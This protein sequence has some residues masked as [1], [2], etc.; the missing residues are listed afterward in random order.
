MRTITRLSVLTLVVILFTIALFGSLAATGE[1]ETR[2]LEK[3]GFSTLHYKSRQNLMPPAYGLAPNTTHRAANAAPVPFLHPYS[4]I[5]VGSWPQVLAAADFTGDNLADLAL[6]SASYFDP[7]NDQRLHLYSG[8]PLTRTQRLPAGADPAAIVAADLDGDGASD[9][10]LALAGDDALALYTQPLTNPTTL[11]LPGA[12]DALASG[13]LNGDLRPDLAAVAPLSA[14]LYLWEGQ[15]AASGDPTLLFALPFPTGGYDALAIGDLDDDGDDDIVALRGAGYLA[16]SVVVYLQQSGSFPLSYTLTPKTGG[17]LPHSLAVGDVNGDG[18]DD[19]V[20]TAGGNAP[21]AY[22]NVFLQQAGTLAMASRTVYSAHHLPSAVAIADLNHDG[23]QDVIAL[24]DAWQ[25]LSV[26]TQTISGTLA[27]YTVAPIPYS[28]R[29]RPDALS[30]ADL[31][32]DGGLDAALVDR[33][34]G[35][36]V[37]ANTLGAPAASISQ[38]AAAS[39]LLPGEHSVSG[40]AEPGA[41]SVEVRLRGHTDWM[42]STLLGEAWHISLTLPSQERA[43]WIEA[44]AIDAQGRVQS[45]PARRRIGVEGGPPQGQII[46]NDGAFATNQPTVTLS[47]PAFDLGGVDAMRFSLDGVFFTDWLTYSHTYTWT[48]AAGDGL[49]TLYAQFQDTQDNVSDLVSDDIILDTLPPSSAMTAL[50]ETVRQSLNTLAWTGQDAGS[51]IDFYDV[52]VQQGG[53]GTL[54]LTGTWTN[55]LQHTS[56]TQTTVGLEKDH[57]YCFRSR[58][59]DR[60]GN[61]EDW[62]PADGDTCAVVNIRSYLYLPIVMRN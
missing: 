8:D 44:R 45:P 13:D 21:D 59:T 62:P 6:A 53:T 58:A 46:I 24:H 60:A 41:I 29:Y 20:V 33:D 47:L 2:F 61:A 15:S 52:Q 28:D 16:N 54:W 14:T 43:W 25:T 11:P 30:L 10:A 4:A 55:L 22:L 18:R 36:I 1:A 5:P 9:L 40:N 35:L 27:A 3:P 51:G 32:G 48:F 42:T 39:V 34:H 56:L 37:L 26:Y 49:K 38:P 12:P 17:Y 50:P 7:S 57:I 23:R 19:L 31:N